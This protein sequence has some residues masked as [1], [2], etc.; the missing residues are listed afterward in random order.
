MARPREFHTDTAVRNA[1]FVFWRKGY[2]ETTMQD[3][4]RATGLGRMSLYN[5]FGGKEDLFQTALERYLDAT[6]RLYAKHLR[7][8]GIADIERLIDTYVHPAPLG[9]AAQWG[10]VMLIAIGAADG[11]SPLARKAIEGLRRF[12]VRK[13]EAELALARECGEVAANADL[14]D[15]AEFIVTSLWGSKMAIRHAR[16][17]AAAAPV[18]RMLRR[19][20]HG[21]RTE[22]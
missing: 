10:C 18:G 16:S 15:A 3:L 14:R 7:G 5:A 11:V 2:A 19:L 6:R 20:L 22:S 9:E 4:E 21:L 12:S 17:A 8:G 13:I 1:L